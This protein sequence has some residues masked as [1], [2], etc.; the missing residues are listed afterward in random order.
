VE[1]RLREQEGA[2][3]QQPQQEPVPSPFHSELPEVLG[4]QAVLVL[5]LGLTARHS[6][7]IGP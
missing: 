5:L 6:L 7:A 1:G 2:T 4:P 3:A